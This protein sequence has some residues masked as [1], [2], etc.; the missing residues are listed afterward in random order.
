MRCQGIETAIEPCAGIVE[1]DC[2]NGSQRRRVSLAPS[3]PEAR[4][5]RAGMKEEGQFANVMN[6]P[7]SKKEIAQDVK[8]EICKVVE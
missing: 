6:D 4:V 1:D 8:R 7:V 2:L 5:V 3:L